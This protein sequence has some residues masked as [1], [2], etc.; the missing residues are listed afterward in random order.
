[1]SC[2]QNSLLYFS[3][4]FTF[5]RSVFVIYKYSADFDS[6]E[7]WLKRIRPYVGAL[8]CLANTHEVLRIER[9]TYT[10][11]LLHN[12][13]YYHFKDYGNKKIYF[14]FSLHRFVKKLDPDVVVIASTYYPL[15]TI[16]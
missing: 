6:P 15:Q 2:F 12:G 5:M 10:G 1:C 11:E 8:E 3:G 13:V 14:P 9:I 4:L 16:L 7:K